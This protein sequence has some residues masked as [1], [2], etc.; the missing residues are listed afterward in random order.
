VLPERSA[1]HNVLRLRL[2]GSE[3]DTLCGGFAHR[4]RVL[5]IP[6]KLNHATVAFPISR[7][8]GELESRTGNRVQYRSK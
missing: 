4:V 2:S 7:P 5:M 6:T 1:K 3:N 8:T